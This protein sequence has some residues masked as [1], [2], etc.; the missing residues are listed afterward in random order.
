MKPERV[1]Y[2]FVSWITAEVILLFKEKE[3]EKVKDE[4]K[5][6]SMIRKKNGELKKTAL[7]DAD[8]LKILT[9]RCWSFSRFA[10][11]L[12]NNTVSR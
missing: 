7:D 8:K 3:I 10:K 5:E 6:N 9:E 1:K 11:Y 2:T 4:L 12:T